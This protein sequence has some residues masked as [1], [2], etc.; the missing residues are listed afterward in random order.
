[1]TA[2]QRLSKALIEQ[3]EPIKPSMAYLVYLME[4]VNLNK[5]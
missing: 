4:W 3:T 2:Q 5:N 1:M